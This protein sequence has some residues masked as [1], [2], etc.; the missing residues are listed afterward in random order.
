[1]KRIALSLIPVL[2]AFTACSVDTSDSNSA[3]KSGTNSDEYRPEEYYNESSAPSNNMKKFNWRRDACTSFGGIIT[4]T[5]GCYLACS[6]NDD[7]PESSSC[8]LGTWSISYCKA[9]YSSLGNNYC[10]TGGG[11]VAIGYDGNCNISCS[12]ELGSYGN[13]YCPSGF[14]CVRNQTRSDGDFYDG[15][16]TGYLGS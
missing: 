7:C 8:V 14:K 5:G 1:M 12:T 11:D 6:S 15:F 16:C 3:S 9:S 10:V 2:M 4:A 13:I